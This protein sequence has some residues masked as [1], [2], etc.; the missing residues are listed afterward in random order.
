MEQQR[1][2]ITQT[3]LSKMDDAGI[4]ILDFK[5]YYNS[6]V[7]NPICCRYKNRYVGQCN[8]I[9]DL[10]MSTHNFGHLICDKD[11]KKHTGENKA[12]LEE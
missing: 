10:N 11:A 1:P 3:N 9:K 6:I 2:Q 5:I 12:S 8:K 4:T 7:M